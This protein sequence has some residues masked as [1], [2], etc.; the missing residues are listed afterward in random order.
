MPSFDGYL[1]TLS[2]A[3]GCERM[4]AGPHPCVR[5]SEGEARNHAVPSQPAQVCGQRDLPAQRCRM[6]LAND[7]TPL[8]LARLQARTDLVAMM[9]VDMLVSSKLARSLQQSEQAN[10]MLT[11]CKDHTVYVL[12]AFEAAHT[13]ETEELEDM[14]ALADN[15]ARQSKAFLVKSVNKKIISPFDYAR[16]PLTLSTR[17]I[18]KP[19]EGSA[20]GV[21]VVFLHALAQ[22]PRRNL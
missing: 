7:A 21:P 19:G 11:T 14:Q 18:T 5:G 13:K 8:N 20:H 1:I 17:L 9:D 4:P 22:Q 15:M 16:F 10:T 2:G 6:K 3:Q 12:P